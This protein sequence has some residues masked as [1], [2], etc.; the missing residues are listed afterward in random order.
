MPSK[1]QLRSEKKLKNV[2]RQ[3]ERFPELLLRVVSGSDIILQ[4]LD[5]RFFEEM[6]NKKIENIIKK[7]NKKIIYVINK[8]DLI[9]RK[10]LDEKKLK[11]LKP[12]VLVSGTKRKGGKGLRDKI[13]VYSE[14]K[15]TT[16]G[17]IGYPNTGKSTVINLLTGKGTAKKGAMPGFTK[18]IHKIRLTKEIILLDSPGVI[19]EEEYSEV[20]AEKIS[21]HAKFSARDY[22]KVKSPEIIVHQIMQE[23]PGK[24][25]TFYNINAKG[26]AEKLIEELGIQKNMFKK[27]GEIHTDKVAR[28]ILRHWQEGKIKF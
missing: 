18:G 14:G 13:K 4:V 27:H 28:L 25:E 16:V 9:D 23:F 21:K 5:A 7:Q 15:E 19:P 24:V 17:V 6:R 12:Y 20:K 1:K 11:N 8:I 10:N 22:N 3:K 2:E 26:D